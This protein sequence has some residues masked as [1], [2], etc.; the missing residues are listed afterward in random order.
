M[1]MAAR[2]TIRYPDASHG[3]RPKASGC[4]APYFLGALRTQRGLRLVALYQVP[5]VLVPRMEAG[6]EECR[7]GTEDLPHHAGLYPH[8]PKQPRPG[9]CAS[10]S[11]LPQQ[12]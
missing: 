11:I 5:I 6:H 8:E 1:D 4:G 10:D 7:P 2:C 3:L 9:L 12:L